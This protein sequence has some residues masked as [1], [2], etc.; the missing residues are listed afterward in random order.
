MLCRAIENDAADSVTEEGERRE[1]IAIL[2]LALLCFVGTSRRREVESGE[3]R[4][5]LGERSVNEE[6]V[7]REREREK[8]IKRQRRRWIGCRGCGERRR[9][10]ERER[11]ARGRTLTRRRRRMR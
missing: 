1:T 8:R 2:R 11:L 4:S 9:Q 6:P 10:G 3:E 5:R 7:A